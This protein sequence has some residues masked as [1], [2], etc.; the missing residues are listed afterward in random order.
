MKQYI[1]DGVYAEWDGNGIWLTTERQDS[2]MTPTNRQLTTSMATLFLEEGR[3]AK[4][5]RLTN[6]LW[7][8]LRE[9]RL[10]KSPEALFRALRLSKEIQGMGM[11][12]ILFSRGRVV[13]A[14]DPRFDGR[15][16]EAEPLPVKTPRSDS[17]LGIKEAFAQLSLEEQEQLLRE[18]RVRLHRTKES[19]NVTTESE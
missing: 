18:I 13:E 7:L 15:A 1:G 12:L 3:E 11:T 4:L 19:R 16:L 17:K 9:V 14:R 6:S 5:R 10:S 2:G 8:E